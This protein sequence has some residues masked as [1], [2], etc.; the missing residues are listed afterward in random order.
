MR[1]FVKAS[2]DGFDGIVKLTMVKYILPKLRNRWGDEVLQEQAKR[3]PTKYLQDLHARAVR[4][5]IGDAELLEARV[6][7]EKLL[8]R[9]ETTLE[10]KP[11]I[12]GEELSLADISVAP[13]VFRLSALGQDQ[14]WS[15]TRRPRVHA[16][17]AQLERRPAFPNRRV[18]AR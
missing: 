13:F 1:E 10:A 7:L 3:R 17:Y 15:A 11:W 6:S 16:W 5:E 4:G 12:A 2:D 14:F 9:L 18:V 8:D